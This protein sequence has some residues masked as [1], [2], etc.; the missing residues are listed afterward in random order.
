MSFD[1]GISPVIRT[2]FG[3]L[4]GIVVKEVST[5]LISGNYVLA[6]AV[7]VFPVGAILFAIISAWFD[8]PY[9]FGLFRSKSKT[10]HHPVRRFAFG[11]AALIGLVAATIW[12]PQ[13]ILK[14]I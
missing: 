4:F 11:G 12:S 2:L 9:T 10:P 14:L 5:A 3:F 1:N 13:Q 7:V 8:S 6:I